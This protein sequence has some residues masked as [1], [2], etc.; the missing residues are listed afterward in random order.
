MILPPLDAREVKARA[1]FVGIVSRYTRLRRVGRQ[2]GGLCPVHSERHP[3]FYVHLEKKV[4]Y[5]FGC[6][7]GGDVFDFVMWV[8]RCD[9]LRAL[10]IVASSPGV[11]RESEPQSGSRVRAGVGAKP[12]GLRSRPAEIARKPE[13]SRH[14]NALREPEAELPGGCEAERAALLLVNDRITGHE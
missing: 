4:F 1:D 3:S 13:P 7:A 5:C 6:G 10:E 12:L 2:W 8:E 9:F 11:A 14:F